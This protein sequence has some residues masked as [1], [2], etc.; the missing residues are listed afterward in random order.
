MISSM[1][2][3]GEVTKMSEI[4]QFVQQENVG[5][6]SW[7]VGMIRKPVSWAVK[8]YLSS[9]AVNVDEEYVVVATVKV[10]SDESGTLAAIS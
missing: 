4:Q 10:T 5:W 2:I 3:V 7:G 8:N 9:G 6:V 1:E